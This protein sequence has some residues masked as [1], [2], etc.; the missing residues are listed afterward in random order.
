MKFGYVRDDAG[1]GNS[2]PWERPDARQSFKHRSWG[3]EMA[4]PSLD[5]C[6]TTLQ[7]GDMLIVF[8][9]DRLGHRPR[10][11]PPSCNTNPR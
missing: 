8:R 1:A 9:L 11:P 3:V 4:L 5:R 10:G 6:L 7:P 2:A